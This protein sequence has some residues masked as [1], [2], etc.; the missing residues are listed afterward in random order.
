M[1]DGS[2]NLQILL[3]A[4]QQGFVTRPQVEE[5]LC[6]WEERYGSSSDPNSPAH[7]KDVVLQKGF[8]NE[9]RLRELESGPNADPARTRISGEILMTCGQCRSERPVS[10]D[11]AL[12]KP[13]CTGCSGVLRFR[14][15]E[16]GTSASHPVPKRPVPEEVR[17]AL[18]DPR[19]RFAKY[20]LLSKLGTG[21]MGEVWRAWDTVLYRLVALKFPRTMGEEEI[22]RLHL[23]AQGAGGLSH[24]NIASIYEIA[25]ADGRHYIAMQ[26]IPGR[27]A[28][29]SVKA[30]AKP[31]SNEIVRW[32]RDAARGVHY[33]HE[34]GVIHRDLKPAN[35]MID[36][37]GRV[38]VMDFGL[39]KLTSGDGSGTVSGVILGTPAFMPPEQ[40]A[41]N[42][43][44]VDRRSD[45]YSLGAMLYVLLSGKRPFDGESATD[46]LVQILTSEPQPLKKVWPE[47]PWELEAILARAMARARDQRYATALELAED[48]DHYLTREPIHARRQGFAVLTARK[49]KKRAGPLLVIGACVAMAL[50]AAILYTRS[51]RQPPPA[52]VGPDRLKLWAELFPKI[53]Q[54]ISADTFDADMAAPLL[55][56]MGRDFPE[57]VESVNSLIDAEQRD[58]IRAIGQLPQ[59]RWIE[60]AARVRRYRDWLTFM[61]RPVDAADRILAYRGTMTLVV[62]VAPYAE[63]RGPL[64]E[65]LPAAERMTPL[66]AKGLEIREGTLELVHPA[67]GS[68][69][70]TLPPLK[71]GTTLTIEGQWKDPTSIKISEGP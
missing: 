65:A 47:A 28:E 31:G 36:T 9:A 19:N 41:A 13:R 15:P 23:E 22:R 58:I 12:R 46:I 17:S 45:V 18:Q 27:T 10:L 29:D 62:Q 59:E 4:V 60:S 8:L 11:A 32:V 54:A 5:C 34:N 21:G 52:P 67:F 3:L 42:A 25:E 40:A 55:E 71:N 57:Q 37:E 39:A 2:R 70:L 64:V 53:Q 7:L 38:F 69:L 49:L 20:V 35:V 56:R 63:L 33:A 50:V 66:C 16:G 43:S 30:P 6:A 1:D 24:P 61:K 51:S 48:L 44:Q 26:F 68:R 14:K